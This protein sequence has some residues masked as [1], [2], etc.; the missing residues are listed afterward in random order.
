MT[1]GEPIPIECRLFEIAEFFVELRWRAEHYWVDVM[2]GPDEGVAALQPLGVVA[3]QLTTAVLAASSA[4]NQSPAAGRLAALAAAVDH[5]WAH[6]GTVWPGQTRSDKL[7]QLANVDPEQ[8]YDRERSMYQGSPLEGDAWGAVNQAGQQVLAELEAG[9]RGCFEVSVLLGAEVWPTFTGGQRWRDERLELA[10]LTVDFAEHV[11]Q[12]TLGLADYVP[13]LS[14]LRVDFSSAT[15]F[16]ATQQINSFWRRV[17]GLLRDPR[18]AAGHLGLVLDRSRGRVYRHGQCIP[19][20]RGR[21]LLWEL[22]V[23]LE[24]SGAHPC[25]RETLSGAWG[26]KPEYRPSQ[27][28]TKVDRAISDLRAALRPLGVRINNTR[29]IGLTLTQDGGGGG[30]A[31]DAEE[32]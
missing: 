3:R 7:N 16:G 10:Y 15:V 12:R 32:L 18:G 9:P 22:L 27:K 28:D 5:F 20:N 19:L 23:R 25:S 4:L 21:R 2:P 24:R 14:R 6:F 29:Q 11:R 1:Q 26:D 30:G 8:A 13:V 17:G 31:Q